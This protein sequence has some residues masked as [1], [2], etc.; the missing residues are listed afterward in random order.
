MRKLYIQ[1][2]LAFICFSFTYFF[3]G[4]QWQEAP[5]SFITDWTTNEVS[6][7]TYASDDFAKEI[8]IYEFD[9]SVKTIDYYEIHDPLTMQQIFAA[10][11]LGLGAGFGFGDNETLWCLHAAYLLRL[12]MFNNSAFY[13]SLGIA[14]DG[15]DINDFKTNLVEL[16]LRLMMFTAITQMREVSLMYGALL[17]YGFGS[18]KYSGFTTDLTR[19]TAA[20]IVGL[21][22]ILNPRM[23]LLLQT[24]LLTYQN[25]T[26]KPDNGSDFDVDNTWGLINKR[27]L[28]TVSLLINLHR[29]RANRL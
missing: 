22:I 16:Q 29:N 6:F 21:H 15:S 9:S 19:L 14:Y 4:A 27:N 17:A 5:Q 20:A 7:S 18:E 25:T 1:R 2:T 10:S 11:M 12:S 28:L 13:G 3:A 24:S 8:D 26:F 23:S